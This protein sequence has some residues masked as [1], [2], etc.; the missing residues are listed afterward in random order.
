LIEIT[1]EAEETVTKQAPAHH[2]LIWFVTDNNRLRYVKGNID[3]DKSSS[4]KKA[5]SIAKTYFM[6]IEHETKKFITEAQI[7]GGMNVPGTSLGLGLLRTWLAVAGMVSMY[8]TVSVKV[9]MRYTYTVFPLGG[10]NEQWNG[11]KIYTPFH[12]KQKINFKC[13]KHT[14]SEPFERDK[15][16]ECECC[17]P[18]PNLWNTI[19]RNTVLS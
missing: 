9:E 6:E 4:Y 13:G 18:E 1:E 17:G 2:G 16:E 11:T 10:Y 3:L 12:D 14:F 19:R 7:S 5:H 15:V 8:G